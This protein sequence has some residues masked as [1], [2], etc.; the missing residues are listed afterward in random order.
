MNEFEAVLKPL[1][2]GHWILTLFL[3][4]QSNTMREEPSPAGLDVPGAKD[5]AEAFMRAHGFKE[6]FGWLS[7][8]DGKYQIKMTV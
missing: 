3:P 7:L 6:F 4:G 8:K 5:W 2:D 1:S